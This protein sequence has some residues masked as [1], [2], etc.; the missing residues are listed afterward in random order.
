M[1]TEAIGGEA[2]TLFLRKATGLI[3][4]WSVRDSIIYACLATS[5]V[6]L[7]IY[8]FAVSAPTFP[9]GQL[10]TAGLSPSVWGSCPA[11]AS[12]GRACAQPSGR[13]EHIR[14]RVVPGT[15]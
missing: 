3:R 1:A 13:R 15:R 5:F 4:G 7:G 2:P 10:I 6:T 11:M 8:A 14:P 12:P 9:K